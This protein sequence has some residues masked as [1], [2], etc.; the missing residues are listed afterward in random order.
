MLLCDMVK[1]N[2]TLCRL[3]AVP[4]ILYPQQL[5]P[6]VLQICCDNKQQERGA[7]RHNMIKEDQ[8]LRLREDFGE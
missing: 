5:A 6:K 8:P 3:H 7:V 1:T 4:M 2:S